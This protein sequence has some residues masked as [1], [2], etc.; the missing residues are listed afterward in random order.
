MR[1]LFTL[2]TSFALAACAYAPMPIPKNATTTE[3]PAPPSSTSSS[4]GEQANT[5]STSNFSIAQATSL[6]ANYAAAMGAAA[7]PRE[8]IEQNL[9]EGTATVQFILTANGQVTNIVVV[10]ASHPAFGAA[11]ADV[12]S[13]YQCRS[14]GKPVVIQVPF[15]F[16]CQ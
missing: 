6:C 2:S 8:A 12:V 1:L 13:R 15:A 14:L 16:H 5:P 10:R 11:A 9:K 4:S 7:F 3:R